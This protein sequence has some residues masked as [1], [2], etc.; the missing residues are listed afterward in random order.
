MR[1]FGIVALLSVIATAAAPTSPSVKV[2]KYLTA[3]STGEF[4]ACYER[5]QN[6]RSAAW[7]YVANRRGGGFSNFGEPGVRQP[8]FIQIS[9]LGSR[10]EI[11]LQGAAS[12]SNEARGVSQCI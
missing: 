2:E 6:R 12:E 8:Y 1:E 10:R 7:V 4:A 5:A 9:D 3:K 11:L